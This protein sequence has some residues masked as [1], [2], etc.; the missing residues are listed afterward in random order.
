[1]NELAILSPI[2]VIILTG[3]AFAEFGIVKRETFK[4]LNGIL[5][6]LAIPA[7]LFRLVAG[8]DVTSPGNLN[9][10][11]A[12]H[13]NYLIMPVIGWAAGKLA[14]EGRDRLAI[15]VLTSMRSNQIFIALPVIAIAMG[16]KGLEP[17]SVYLAVSLVGYHMISVAASQIALSG[18]ISPESLLISAKK[19]AVNPMV[20]A[21]LLG[22]AFSL[23]GIHEFP[24]PVD[25]T[26]KVMGDVGTGMALMAVGSG[27]SF[28]SLPSMLK[29]TWRDC[30]VKLLVQPVILLG[31]FMIW[32]VEKAMMQVSVFACAMPVAV[33]T[34]VASQGMGMDYKYAGELIAVTTVLSAATIPLWIRLLGI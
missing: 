10:F 31:L 34:L 15:S 9:L 24:H 2:A 33:N 27:L 16:T 1:M 18:G 32:P 6:W 26:L 25:V 17:L 14:G 19:L 5:Y 21:C 23:S 11:F 3:W 29:K 4:D 13:A 28:R 12:V 30:I 22:A 8:V 7:T 20:L